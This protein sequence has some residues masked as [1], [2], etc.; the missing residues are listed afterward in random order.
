MLRW[1]VTSS[2]RPVLCPC[3]LQPWEAQLLSP[4]V[5]VS[6]NLT[7]LKYPSLLHSP[8]VPSTQRSLA[9]KRPVRSTCGKETEHLHSASLCSVLGMLR[10]QNQ[11]PTKPVSQVD[12]CREGRKGGYVV[13][14][15]YLNTVVRKGLPEVAVRFV[16]QWGTVSQR[17]QQVQCAWYTQG[18][19]KN[20]HSQGG[21]RTGQYTRLGKSQ[22]LGGAG[23]R[24]QW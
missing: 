12:K 22:G 20:G 2:F 16:G 15:V 5:C 17:K 19:R 14:T 1:G 24:R 8:P 21:T 4:T 6:S 3:Q 18:T 9:N 23:P 7:A 13:V 11:V 10:E